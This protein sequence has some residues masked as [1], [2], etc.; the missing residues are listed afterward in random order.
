MK[1]ENVIR[2]RP[3]MPNELAS[4]YTVSG[5]TMTNW[6]KSI[7]EKVGVRLGQYYSVRQVEIIFEHFGVPHNIEL[8][9]TDKLN[10]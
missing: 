3:Y 6:I 2:V 1:T 4:I 7:K 9:D 5:P 8:S 10:F